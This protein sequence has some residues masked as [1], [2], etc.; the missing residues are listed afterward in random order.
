MK[1]FQNHAQKITPSL[2]VKYWDKRGI[3]SYHCDAEA[4]GGDVEK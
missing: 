4:K 2:Y 3:L 1:H